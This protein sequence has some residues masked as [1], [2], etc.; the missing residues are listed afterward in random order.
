VSVFDPRWH[1]GVV[2]LIASRVREKWHRPAIAFA[3]SAEGELTGSARS[4]PGVHI[5]DLLESVAT[6]HPGLLRRF[7]GHAMA[8][9]LTL[10]EKD[11]VVFAD[12]AAR[13]LR[14]LY[15][16]AD[17]SGVILTDGELPS[18][19][20]NLEFARLLREAGPWGAG[21]SE[22]TFH[23]EFEIVEQRKVGDRHLKM[24]VRSA[25]DRRVI[26]A[27]AF[28]QAGPDYGTHAQLTY[29]LDINDY[30]GSETPPL[31]VA[32]IVGIA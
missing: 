27:I 3:R 13:Q 23:G 6:T 15:P 20:L 7:G 24:K 30:R 5:R 22:P 29:R 28:R 12:A 16:Q 14:Q 2:G 10:A 9:G 32:Q 11:F 26:D 4:G 1:Q 25:D 18:S 8:A 17:F 21:F 19:A 31:V